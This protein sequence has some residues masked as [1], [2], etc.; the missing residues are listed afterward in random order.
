MK[1]RLLGVNV[2]RGLVVVTVDARP[3]WAWLLCVG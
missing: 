1:Q 2:P 3:R